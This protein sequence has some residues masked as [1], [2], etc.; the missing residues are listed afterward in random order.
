MTTEPRTIWSAYFGFTP[1]RTETSTVSSHFEEILV[2]GRTAQ[3][4][5]TEYFLSGS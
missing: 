3:A 4:S 5:A 2:F 1:R